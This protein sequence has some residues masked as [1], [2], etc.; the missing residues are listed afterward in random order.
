[1][2]NDTTKKYQL[3]QQQKV[4]SSCWKET[5]E[6]VINIKIIKK[7]HKIINLLKR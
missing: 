7:Y 6:W 5:N 2:I 4:F 3:W 1:M